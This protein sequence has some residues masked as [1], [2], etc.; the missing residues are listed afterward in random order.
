MSTEDDDWFPNGSPQRNKM[1]Q[2][3]ANTNRDVDNLNRSLESDEFYNIP[4]E[5]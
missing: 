1:E 2:R 3:T 5:R 4:L